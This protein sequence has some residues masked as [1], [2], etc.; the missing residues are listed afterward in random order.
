MAYSGGKDSTGTLDIFV[1]RYGLRVLAITFDNCFISEGAKKNITAVC[2]NLAVDHLMIRPSAPMMHSVF[3]AAAAEEL[4]SSKTLERASTICTACI[5][6]VKSVTLRTAIEKSIPFVGFGWSPGQAPIES[7]VMKTN[8]AFVKMT[9]KAVYGPLHRI[10]GD[11]IN[12]YFLFEEHFSAA[13]SFP[14]NIHPLAFLDYDE[15][16][17]IQRC[18]EIGWKRPDDTDAN[19]TNCLLNAFANEVHISRYGFHPYAF[20]IA[21]LVRGGHMN[22]EEGL[23]KLSVSMNDDVI[24]EVKFRLRVP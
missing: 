16:A 10:A 23:E 19:S 22:R 18:G 12:P 2:D 17:V 15:Q 3:R 11:G 9:Q 1:N 20:E 24:R 7:S 4:F 14:W 13:E 21:G 6:F 5:S 8:A